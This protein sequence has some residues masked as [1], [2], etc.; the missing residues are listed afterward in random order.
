MSTDQPKTP[1]LNEQA[2][3]MPEETLSV[4]LSTL[5]L[6]V[7][8][9]A[10]ILNAD[11]CN[12][13]A[14]HD[15]KIAPLTQ[16]NYTFLR[17]DQF[18]IRNDILNH[19]DLHAT[20]PAECNSRFTDLG[21]GEKWPKRE[22]VYIHWMIPRPYRVGSAVRKQP[23][24]TPAETDKPASDSKPGGSVESATMSAA[25]S[26][27]GAK[28]TVPDANA[29]GPEENARIP[30][31]GSSTFH[32]VPTRWLVI[33]KLEDHENITKRGINI[34][35][36]Q[37]WVVESDR[38]WMLD[39][40]P[41]DW[42][43]QVDV[44]PFVDAGG[45]GSADV[46]AQAEI[47]I[48]KKTAVEDWHE[49]GDAQPR[50]NLTLL[51]SSNQLFPDYQPHNS[52]VFSIVDPFE[53]DTGDLD[54]QGGKIMGKL[55][56]ATASY[57][58]MGWHSSD[59]KD[60]MHIE[61]APE[62]REARMAAHM[63]ELK[64]DATKG[65]AGWK[66]SRDPCRILCHGAMYGVGWSNKGKPKHVPAD[67][68]CAQLTS[69]LP[70]AI[71]T[72]PMDALLTYVNSHKSFDPDDIKEI[73]VT[74]S[75]LQRLLHARDDGVDAQREVA[76]MVMNWNHMQFQGGK[77]FF[78]SGDG[79]ADHNDETVGTANGSKP[80]QPTDDEKALLRE[81]N[82][83][84]IFLDAQNRVFKRLQWQ[85]FSMWWKYLSDVD[86]QSRKDSLKLQ[87][88]GVLTPKLDNVKGK[89][90]SYQTKI[91]ELLKKLPTAT[92]GVQQPFT[93]TRDPTLLV[94]GIKSG[95][96]DE[97]LKKV[98]V[99]IA[100]Q[101]TGSYELLD[102]IS[103][104]MIGKIPKTLRPAARSL[105][106]EF[107]ALAPDGPA[108]NKDYVEPLYHDRDVTADSTEFPEPPWRD[109]W[110]NIQ[111]WFPLFLE[112]EGEY[113]H[114][115]YDHWELD[116]RVVHNSLAGPR[117]RYG[118]KDISVLCTS[119]LAPPLVRT[120]TIS[121][122]VLILPQPNF[123][124]S[125]KVEQLLSETSV[126]QLKEEGLTEDNI[127]SLRSDLS[128]LQFLSA[129]L[130][131]FTNH[132]TTMVEGSHVK[133]TIRP[134]GEANRPLDA[135]V[136]AG[137]PAGFNRKQLDYIGGECDLTPY[138]TLVSLAQTDTPFFPV[139]HGQ[140]R[141]TKINIIDKF[142]QAIHAMNPHPDA[143]FGT[144]VYPCIS[145]F[146]EPQPL[147]ANNE[148]ANTVTDE[149]APNCEHIQIAPQI[150]QPARLNSCFVTLTAA[151]TLNPGPLPAE[152]S[153]APWR[154]VDEW[155]NPIWGWVVVN[156]ADSGVQ[157]FLPD[158]TF[159]REVRF[160]GPY[161][162][163]K[164]PPWL[165]FEPPKG[166]AA[167]PSSSSVAD[168]WKFSQ[169][170]IFVEQLANRDFLQSFIWMINGA[171]KNSPPAPTAYAEFV[172]SVIGKPMALVNMG[173]SVELADAPYTN[174]SSLSKTPPDH[175]LAEVKGG[176]PRYDFKIKLGDKDRAFDGLIGYFEA[177][178]SPTL[179]SQLQLDQIFTH[180]TELP[181][182][183]IPTTAAGSQVHDFRTAINNSK[184]PPLH[185]DYV[186][187]IPDIDP[188]DSTTIITPAR[189][190]DKKNE[191]LSVFGA[192]IDPFIATHGYTGILPIKSLLLPSWTWQEAMKRMTG[193]FHIG[194][195]LVTE[196][197]PPY[198]PEFKLTSDYN[199]ATQDAKKY[200]T[201]KIGIPA[202][203][204]A[205]WS[206]LQPYIS[207][208]KADA[209]TDGRVYMPLNI[210]P[211]DDR[212][213]FEP[214][215]YTAVEGYLQMKKPILRPDEKDRQ[216]S[217]EGTK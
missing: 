112:W 155:E 113:T 201:A 152:K 107:A 167:P 92:S 31:M 4:E 23:A 134:Q 52:N 120:R 110:E 17:L 119:D 151:D 136:E 27:T 5:L 109:R 106:H 217:V 168:G 12:G 95:W 206:W 82:R 67:K 1:P 85:M 59:V 38:K 42:D 51:G 64:N 144:K 83:C 99:R 198:S 29:E 78:L 69:K 76:D 129:P 34:P 70:I 133:P 159:Y 102:S 10:F 131:G 48:G 153:K 61:A 204:L 205:D 80:T 86:G 194:P 63:M 139:T 104:G 24:Q 149:P 147:V 146:Y 209:D 207:T 11:V 160:G 39:Q 16:P 105:L 158:G 157:V 156:F 100:S 73:E 137:L 26:E 128:K 178:K 36:V 40:I 8:V 141:F 165:P 43:L 195:L 25:V 32:E 7:K 127:K 210:K 53:Y 212:P 121:G 188:K 215:P 164:S 170:Q 123:S 124:L 81:L 49:E 97:F 214:A 171:M 191:L 66:T 202:V 184:Y 60:P 174:E 54:E 65:I 84:Q 14:L 19:A 57:Y 75:T 71:G 6:P 9:D 126:E 211:I 115:P 96:P 2:A 181:S 125:S 22:G 135:A 163:Q 13:D 21:T 162:V 56:E 216:K 177:Q 77:R 190:E 72:T 62:N 208:D 37:A 200:P 142:G 186:D 35:P 203:A 189:Y 192:L 175:G 130:S 28:G 196:D 122:R 68:A 154:P 74:I 33:R 45:T 185:A 88:Q 117:L 143:A 169:L 87:V 44:S 173:W 118:I 101:I 55:E 108:L 111:P 138:G 213:R 180:Y 114:I 148:K 140:F 47:F 79:K 199:L 172:N 94:G 98:K 187:P 161:G 116:N 30:D 93:Q 18:Y 145:D 183:A 176:P 150:N 132:L 3:K 46:D 103:E 50:V 90:Q 41:I 179:D 166:Q 193:F 182:D 91:A 58:V 89:I 197:V 15:A 20:T